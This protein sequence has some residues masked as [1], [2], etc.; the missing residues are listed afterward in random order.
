MASNCEQLGVLAFDAHAGEYDQFA[1]VQA[2]LAQWTAQWFSAARPK[3]LEIGA[4]TGIFTGHLAAA[5]AHLVATDI[6]PAM[7]AVARGK[8]P[9]VQFLV[10]DAR[11]PFEPIAPIATFDWVVSS[12][13]LQWFSEPSEVLCALTR[14][15]KPGG[16]MLHGLL[17]ADSLQVLEGL[18]RPVVFRSIDQWCALFASVG[19]RTIRHET[20][21]FVTKYPS[22]QSLL[23]SIHRTGAIAPQKTSA[24]ILRA[25]ISKTDSKIRDGELAAEW[26]FARI[27]CER[28]AGASNDLLVGAP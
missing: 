25:W 18:P 13:V 14:T 9:S 10:H 19:M 15:L 24:A 4:G 17:V 16:R 28:V 20:R 23:K 27:E 7:L 5:G 22:A 21:H 26:T 6:A 3:C 2:A 8:F 12:A 1:A 11:D